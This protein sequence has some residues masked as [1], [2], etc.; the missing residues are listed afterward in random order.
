M[1]PKNHKDKIVKAAEDL[2]YRRGYHATSIGAIARAAG[3]PKG[4]LYNHF[5]G[6]SDLAAHLMDR[7]ADRAISQLEDRLGSKDLSPSRLVQNLLNGYLRAY[8]R[9]GYRYG[10]SLGSRLNEVADTDRQL[11][12]RISSHLESWASLLEDRFKRWASRH[13]RR[14]LE[15]AAPGLA[16]TVQATIQGALLQMKGSRNA[17]PLKGARDTL[18]L[19]LE[20]L[21]RGSSIGPR[22][23]RVRA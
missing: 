20:G 16:R 14:D 17:A 12:K 1:N 9:N 11:S 21:E 19:L 6:K 8:R 4:S 5:K 15:R 10:C 18:K 2:L 13:G 3:V 22:R 23:R 7:F